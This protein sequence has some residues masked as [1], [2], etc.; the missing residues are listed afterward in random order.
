MIHCLREE[1]LEGALA[2][3]EVVVHLD[4]HVCQLHY[5]DRTSDT[6]HD[7]WSRARQAITNNKPSNQG[8]AISRDMISRCEALVQSLLHPASRWLEKPS[9]RVSR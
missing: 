5:Y 9:N 2:G 4:K 7:M 3:D 1:E 8:H 6:V